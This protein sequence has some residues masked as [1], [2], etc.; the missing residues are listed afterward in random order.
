[1]PVPVPI[2]PAIA[3][4]SRMF[5]DALGRYV[6]GVAFVTAAPGGRPDGLIVNSLASVS[7]DPPLV[8]F[9]RARTPLPWC[10]MGRAGRFGVNVLG[11]GHEPFA[12][13]AA[14]AGA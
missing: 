4:D 13:R 10:P 7:L 6:T 3:P 1:M 11:A 5:R 14:P 9:C 8:S 12:V 2:S